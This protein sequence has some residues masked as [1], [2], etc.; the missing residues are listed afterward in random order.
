MTRPDRS[1]RGPPL[2]PGI[3]G[4]IGLN[5]VVEGFA[6]RRENRPFQ[7]AYNADRDGRSGL[8]SQWI[9]DG[10]NS[11]ADSQLGGH[12]KLRRNSPSISILINAKSVR[13]SR[14]ATRPGTSRPS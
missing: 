5:Q 7:P 11:F 12:S 1:T 6:R 2:L 14:P 4:G 9:S 3:Q 13:K 8:D 10:H